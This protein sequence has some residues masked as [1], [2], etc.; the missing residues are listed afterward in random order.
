[1]GQNEEKNDLDKAMDSKAREST[2]L[3][4]SGFTQ[5]RAKMAKSCQ[6][7]QRLIHRTYI[8]MAFAWL[9]GDLLQTNNPFYLPM[10]FF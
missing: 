5:P 1:M 4:V 2:R 8:P 10:S 9:C 7:A 3:E 6:Q